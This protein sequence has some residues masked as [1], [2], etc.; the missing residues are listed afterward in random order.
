MK[1]YLFD[2]AEA[3]L[4]NTIFMIAV[5]LNNLIFNE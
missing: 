1:D 3:D 2:L 5:L 4:W